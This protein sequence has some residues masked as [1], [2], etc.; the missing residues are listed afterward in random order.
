[1]TMIEVE[2]KVSMDRTAT[3]PAHH[4]VIRIE[5]QPAKLRPRMSPLTWPTYQLIPSQNR[6]S[7]RNLSAD[8]DQSYIA[9]EIF[10]VD[11]RRGDPLFLGLAG[12]LG[13]VG[14]RWFS[15]RETWLF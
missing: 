1:M 14:V 12:C 10:I 8:D 9:P 5:D 15:W 3:G 13:L 4:A 6:S 2:E 7:C 11:I